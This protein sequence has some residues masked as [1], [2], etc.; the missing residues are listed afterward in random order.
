MASQEHEIARFTYKG[1]EYPILHVASQ[2]YFKLVI[3]GHE[4]RLS[5]AEKDGVWDL[6]RAYSPLALR[7]NGVAAGI[8]TAALEEA[9]KKGVRVI[10]SCSYVNWFVGNHMEFDDLL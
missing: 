6:Y 2:H 8:T 7:E 9:R 4:A 10:P 1:K 5:Y 3:D